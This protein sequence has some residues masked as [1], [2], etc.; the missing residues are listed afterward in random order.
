VE[1][2]VDMVQ[3]ALTTLSRQNI[4]ELD[5]ERKAQMVSNMLV[6]LASERDTQPVFNTSSLY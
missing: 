5:E 3:T 1:A 6:V 4:V 2:A